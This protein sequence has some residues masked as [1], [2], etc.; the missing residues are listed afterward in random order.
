MIDEL[1]HFPAKAWGRQE[2]D[3]LTQWI[4]LFYHKVCVCV[5]GVCVCVW[6]VCVCVCVWVWVWV[7]YPVQVHCACAGGGCH[8]I[9]T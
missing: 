2:L 7:V 1:S 3:V 6:C 8:R 5:C 9:V 4:L